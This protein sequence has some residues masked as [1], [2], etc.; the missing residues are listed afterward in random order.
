MGCGCGGGRRSSLPRRR[1]LRPSVGPR[2]IVGQ[3]AAGATPAQLR[4]LGIQQT[5]GQASP[6]RLDEDRRRIEKLRREAVKR[7]LGK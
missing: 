2:S 7:R 5:T 4:A 6:K 1:E 3:S